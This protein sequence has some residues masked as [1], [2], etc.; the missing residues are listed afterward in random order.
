MHWSF[1]YNCIV[2]M[3]TADGIFVAMQVGNQSSVNASDFQKVKEI[4]GPHYTG[5]SAT[6]VSGDYW[7]AALKCSPSGANEQGNYLTFID[8]PS[9]NPKVI[10]ENNFDTMYVH[11]RSLHLTSAPCCPPLLNVT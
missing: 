2:A 6:F 3:R 10:E 4:T 9:R 7:Y 1:K 8:M 11:T 5:N